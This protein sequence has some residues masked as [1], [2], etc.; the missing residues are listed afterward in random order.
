VRAWIGEPGLDW[1]DFNALGLHAH[2]SFGFGPTYRGRLDQARV[3][4]LADQTSHDDLFLGRALCGE[5]GQYLTGWLHAAG[6]TKSY[7]ILRTLPVDMLSSPT[8][9]V[10]TAADHPAVALM[11]LP[12]NP[13]EIRMANIL[14][15]DDDELLRGALVQSLINAGHNVIEASDG[16]RGCEIART[17]SIVPTGAIR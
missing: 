16:L 14:L 15:I 3:V 4:I 1:P 5:A 13:P 9:A 2:R 10:K 6:L 12:T 17:T 7:A 8:A 11:V